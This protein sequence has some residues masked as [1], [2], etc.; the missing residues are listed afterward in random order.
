[1][2][3]TST[4]YRTFAEALYH[5]LEQDAFYVT[6][7]NSVANPDRRKQAML[8]YLEFSMLEAK[9]YGRLYIP[10]KHEYGVSVWN[11]PQTAAIE[12]TIKQEK[13]Q[14]LLEKMG[15]A[16]AE[17]YQKIVAEMSRN[18][19]KVVHEDA[20]Y[21]SIVGVR[22]EFQNKG[23]GADLII[24]VLKEADASGKQTYLE[25]FGTRNQTFYGR[26]GFETIALYFEPNTQSDYWVMS[27]EPGSSETGGQS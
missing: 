23:L 6:L 8:D 20:W 11:I 12:S 25:T 19:S 7:E 3:T 26:L 27:R 16:S 4:H 22:P 10:E 18:T 21:L 5:A 24:P 17:C 9:Q 2:N 15:S 14:F 13:M 1:M